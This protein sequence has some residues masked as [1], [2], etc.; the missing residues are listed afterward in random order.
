MMIS[1]FVYLAAIILAPSCALAE[2]SDYAVINQ[3]ELKKITEGNT[4]K[5]KNSFVNDNGITYY[6]GGYATVNTENFMIYKYFYRKNE[7][8]IS[9]MQDYCTKIYKKNGRYFRKVTNGNKVF[10]VS[11]TIKQ[12]NRL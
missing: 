5:D 9:R 11:L 7:V 1:R 6:K 12:G 3:D 4:I 8:C 10:Y 2:Q